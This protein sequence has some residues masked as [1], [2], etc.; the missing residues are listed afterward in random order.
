MKHNKKIVNLTLGAAIAALYAVL[1]LAM[2]QFSSLQ[3]QVRLSEAL[4]ILPL[5]TNAAVPGLYIGCVI[6]NLL[7]GNV[8]D[9]VFGALA[10][11]LASVSTYFI[12]RKMK[13]AARL[14]LAPLPAVVFNVIAVPLVLYYGYGFTS[15][16]VGSSV[17]SGFWSVLGLTAL[18]VF[19]GQM[20]ACY[21]VGIP[22]YKALEHIPALRDKE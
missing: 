6:A 19:I 2:W 14:I 7:A 10:T 16:E 21:G 9:A 5:F 3:I 17:I 12:G 1:T 11:L 18:S 4:C 22:L 15:F 20:I 13:G 8:I